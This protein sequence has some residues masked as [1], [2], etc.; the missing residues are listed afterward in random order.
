MDTALLMDLDRPR[1]CYEIARDDLLA[2]RCE[3]GHWIGE[4]STSSLSTATAVSALQ[5]V[6]RHDPSQAERLRPLVDGGVRYLTEHQNCDGGWGDTDRSYSN[7]ATTM[8][9]VAALSIA[10]RRDELSQAIAFA[11]NYIE[12]QGGIPGLRRRY[13]KD[14]TFAVPILTNYALA[15]LVDWSEVSPLPFE[16]ACLPQKFYKLVKLPVVSYAIPALVAIGQ[17]R[18]FHRPPWNPLLRSVR[19]AAVRKSRDVL[20]RMQP[21]SG[22]YLE[23]APLTSFV[24]MSLASIEQANHPVAR[25][26]VQFLVDSVRP[27]GSWPIDT[28]LANWVTTLSVNALASGGENIAELNCLP[29]VLANQYQVTHP[30]TGADPGGW[31]WTDLSGSVPDADD[32]PGAMLAIAHFF[33][34]PDADNETR[35]K[36]VSAA[37][38]GARWLLGL[39]NRD[40]GW[41]T[42]CEGWG[43][44]PFDRSGSDLTAHGIRALHAWRSELK[45]LPIQRAIER[46][47]RY[48][49]KQQREDGTWLPLWFGNQDQRDDENP[50]YGTVKVLLAYRDLGMMASD[51]AQKG[52]A[53]L[54]ANQN[55]DGGFG[56]GPSVA[57]LCGGAGRSGVEETALAIEALLAAE[58]NGF[59]PEITAS[60]VRWLCQRVEE[61]SHVNVSPI[62]FYFSKLWY[63]E[64]LYPRI[65]TVAS[66]GAALQANAS[67]PPAPETLTTSSDH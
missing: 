5:L 54:V 56:G 1:R 32:T 9:A 48:L 55:E 39:Q 2:Q 58:N 16:L 11:E 37:R 52:I 57:T 7:I 65:M 53:W 29:W 4:L 31:G 38:Q 64:K 61:G 40:G 43:T 8:L 30:F 26:G 51:S 25:Q 10:G 6:I 12:A 3:Q 67:V 50:I 36:L 33:R 41:P 44:Q 24:V 34:S 22:G 60:A 17:A 66:L 18:Y 45:D 49:K 42:F 59:L 46:G 23:A 35:R 14:K 27:D 62:G 63:Y 28:N 15:G 20:R 13:G 47:F 19:A 21:A